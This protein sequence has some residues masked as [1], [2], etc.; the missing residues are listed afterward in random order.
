M[1]CPTIQKGSTFL[2]LVALLAL[3]QYSRAPPLDE[4][5]YFSANN[6]VSCIPMCLEFCTYLPQ[7]ENCTYPS[8]DSGVSCT[9]LESPRLSRAFYPIPTPRI[10]QYQ[11]LETT[12]FDIMLHSWRYVFIPNAPLS[13]RMAQRW[14]V[15]SYA[16]L[17]L[18]LLKSGFIPASPFVN[19]YP[20]QPRYFRIRVLGPIRRVGS[21]AIYQPVRLIPWRLAALLQLVVT[22]DTW[23]EQFE[24]LERIN[25]IREPNWNFDSSSSCKRLVSWV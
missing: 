8:L 12:L 17:S 13:K 20:V 23:A 7:L 15:Q 11:E 6:N 22:P 2:D 14:L 4:V 16:F 25:S 3:C 10:P 24:R 9:R 1:E 5:P 19:H 21:L 18:E